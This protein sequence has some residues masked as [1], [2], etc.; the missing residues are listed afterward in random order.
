MKN[1]HYEFYG[2]VIHSKKERKFLKEFCIKNNIPI[3]YP[4]LFRS[5]RL[6]HLW[7]IS[8]KGVGLGG[9][10]IFRNLSSEQII[11]DINDLDRILITN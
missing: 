4:N 1:E 5:I 6:N 8:K 9:T 7:I 2:V 10:L 11:K 3:T